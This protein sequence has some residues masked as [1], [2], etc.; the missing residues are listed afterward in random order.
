MKNIISLFL[1]FSLSSCSVSKN[2][3]IILSKVV[4]QNE[5]KDTINIFYTTCDFP[6]IYFDTYKEFKNYYVKGIKISDEHNLRWKYDD[7]KWTIND[8]DIEWMKK[9]INNQKKIDLTKN[10][11]FRENIIY[12]DYKNITNCKELDEHF[13][14]SI[15]GGT[16]FYRL[17]TPLMNKNKTKAIVF[18]YTYYTEFSKVYILEK[19]NGN[20]QIITD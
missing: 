17:S 3:I 14:N 10:K 11:L 19:I 13:I 15:T 8:S 6:E 20:W 7:F 1:I 4:N 2:E 12:E 18:V 9:E 5:D 16:R